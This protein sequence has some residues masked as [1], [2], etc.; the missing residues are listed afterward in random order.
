M[1]KLFLSVFV[2]CYGFVCEAQPLYVN[3]TKFIGG[4]V[5]DISYTATATV[6][7][8]IVF[9]GM[10]GDT[11]GLGD[12]P[13]SP[14]DSQSILAN[15]LLVGKLDSNRQ[16]AWVKVYGGHRI[17]RALKV[18]QVSDGGYAVLGETE[19]FDGNISFNRGKTEFWLI[20]LDGSGNLLWEKT[21]GSS[22]SESPLSLAATVD[23]GFIMLGTSQGSDYD[24]PFHYGM[25]QFN[26][27]WFV[28]K[29]DS[30]GT[31]Q[32][33]KTLG[34]NGD[35]SFNRGSIIEA[36]DGYYL[37]GTSNS[38]DNDCTDTS[39][40]AGVNSGYDVFMLKLDT[41]GNVLWNKSYGGSENEESAVGI[42][43]PRDSSLLIAVRSIS[44]DYML[45][46]S[47]TVPVLWTFKTD[48]NG[49]MI[50]GTVAGDSLLYTSPIGILPYG[51]SSY[52]LTTWRFT[53][54]WLA[55]IDSIGN[56]DYYKKV[57]GASDETS[58]P[59]TVPYKGGY[60]VVGTTMSSS[61]HEGGHINSCRGAKDVF[62][63]GLNDYF[64]PVGLKNNLVSQGKL[65]VY[66]NPS[67]GKVRIMLPVDD[68]GAI[69][70]S[71]NAG[72]KIL[73]RKT[74]ESELNIETSNW[75]KGIYLVTWEGNDG[76]KSS[77]KLIN[78]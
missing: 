7:G 31:I 58:L 33:A 28:I 50:W 32:W 66:P 53:N 54:Y 13:A 72:R 34:G 8:G 52:L 2:L 37:V 55:I 48:M 19:S 49:N 12:I 3:W 24:V 76:S 10:T 51:D 45:P 75:P 15:N 47:Y 64:L 18:I 11:S 77:A 44:H 22:D 6:D 78:N 20:R 68:K 26:Q 9:A 29:V 38:K 69:T 43:D 23:G 27:D 25:A 41:A 35:E 1:K 74:K 39:W 17:D 40:H 5:G 61:M 59:A 62:V 36:L 16:L 57:G 14:P 71:D 60:A 65:E 21:Y 70:I 63:S 73:Q 30:L 67:Q 56:F 42:F 4:A 46:N